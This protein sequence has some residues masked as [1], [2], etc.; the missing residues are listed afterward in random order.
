MRTCELIVA[1]IL[2]CPA[3]AQGDLDI[4]PYLERLRNGDT[5]E[6]RGEVSDLAEQHPND[7][8]IRYLQGLVMEDGTDAARVFQGLVD[9]HPK[10]E[11]ADDALYK[12]YQFYYSLGL[13]RTAEL[14]WAQLQREYPDSPHLASASGGAKP[15][16]PEQSSDINPPSGETGITESAAVSSRGEIQSGQFALQAGAYSARENAEKQKLFFEDQGFPVE[17]INRVKDTQS[18]FLVLVGNYLTYDEAKSRIA[19]I[20]NKYGVESFVVSR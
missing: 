7:A 20:R 12:V 5:G 1:V 9:R 6:L 13:Y 16:Q 4:A 10:S 11:W 18:L 17:V 15:S 19:E 8:G 2:A 14:K 3:L